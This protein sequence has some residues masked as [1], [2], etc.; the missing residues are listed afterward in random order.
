MCFVLKTRA[1]TRTDDKTIETHV[2]VNVAP[3]DGVGAHVGVEIPDADRIVARAGHE[4]ASGQW[5]LHAFFERWVRL[6]VPGARRVVQKPMGFANLS[7]IK[8]YDR[9]LGCERVQ[10]KGMDSGR[11]EEN[12]RDNLADVG[13]VTEVEAAIAVDAGCSHQVTRYLPSAKNYTPL[14]SSE[15]S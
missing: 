4:R 15:T 12:K 5:A 14:S 8:S 11:R 7:Y 10:E 13:D 6:D 3:V 2:A 1:R 9:P